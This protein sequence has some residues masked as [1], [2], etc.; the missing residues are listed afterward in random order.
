MTQTY[1]LHGLMESG[2]C[3]KIALMLNLCQADWEPEFV[4]LFEPTRRQSFRHGVNVQNEIPVL[5]HGNITLSQSGVILTYLSENTGRFAA[6]SP[7]EAR[8]VLRWLLFDNHRLSSF[9]AMTRMEHGIKKSPDTSVIAF[10]RHHAEAAL[11]VV[12][13][14]LATQDFVV[15]EVPTI[16]D[17]SLVGYL[18]FDEETGI[19]LD[20]FP[21]IQAWK[22][23]IAALP[24]WAHPYDMPLPPG[25]DW[26]DPAG[27]RWPVH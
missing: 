12:N 5:Q 14:R 7:D 11:T 22:Q 16:A 18:Y 23:R 8:E 26:T 27:P 2:N 19:D 13:D 25:L 9:Y 21:N 15:S 20:A 4:D 6:R 10:V 3:Y 24:G 1:R 17:L